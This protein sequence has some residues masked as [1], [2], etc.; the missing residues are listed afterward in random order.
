[1]LSIPVA[2]AFTALDA[3]VEAVGGLDWDCL[4]ARERLEALGR[5]ET[6]RRR[7]TASSHDIAGS[8]DRHDDGDIGAILHKVIADVLRVSLGEARRRLRDARQLCPRTTLTGQPVPAELP[9]TA[10]AWEAGL[11]DPDHLRVIQKFIRD[12][13]EHL[14]PPEVECAEIFLAEKAAEL[15]P[16][17]LEK[18]ADRLAL[19]LNPDGKFSDDD[20]ALRRG[21]T[22]CGR[23][24]PDGMSVGKLIA[25][26]QLRAELD[27]GFAKF[28]APGMCNPDDQSPT[29]T[30]EPTQIV[31]DRDARGHAQRQHDALSALVR[32]QLGDPKLG[33]HNGLPVTIIVS[34]TLEQLQARAGVAVTAGGSLIPIPDLIRMAGHANHYL[35]IFEDHTQRP[36]YLGR[37]KRIATG[38]QRIVLHAKDRGCTAPG[39]DVP[40]YLSEVHHV[41]EWADGGLTNIDNLAFACKL[42]H[43]LIKP[44]GWRTRKRSDGSTQWIPP[45][46]LP[47]RGGTND[48][49]H[50]ERLLPKKQ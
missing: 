27:A 50:P 22:W 30:T 7:Q 46:K 43:G 34:A 19:A 25:S 20:R 41:D 44:G 23:Q 8:L 2:E 4:P 42:D 17:Q 5:L 31:M 3:A 21:F 28:A 15:R 36:L 49:H 26:A 37:T 11:L 40:G 9:A 35:A 16:D 32:G 24:R 13:P 18:V 45:P 33:Q 12:L 10:K 1:M 48:Y 47:L 6:V 39:C 14:P 38:D 29:V